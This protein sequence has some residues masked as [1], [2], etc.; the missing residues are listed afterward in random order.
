MRLNAPV[1][2]SKRHCGV[3]D[4]AESPSTIE[5][6]CPTVEASSERRREEGCAEEPEHEGYEHPS[7]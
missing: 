4:V 1:D 2:P 3:G 7:G 6:R 5:G